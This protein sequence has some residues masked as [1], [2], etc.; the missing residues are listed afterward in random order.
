MLCY[1]MLCYIY[2]YIYMLVP[3]SWFVAFHGFLSF[4]NLLSLFCLCMDSVGNG[5]DPSWNVWSAMRFV[6]MSDFTGNGGTLVLLA[7]SIHSYVCRLLAWLVSC[8]RPLLF[9]FIL[10]FNWTGVKCGNAIFW[11]PPLPL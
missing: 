10:F 2:I 3:I 9:F 6:A 5:K 7:Q 11:M 8:S 4:F 1:A